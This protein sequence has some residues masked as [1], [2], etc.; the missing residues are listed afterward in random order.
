MADAN[1]YHTNL[2]I[3]KKY[4]EKERN[5]ISALFRVELDSDLATNPQFVKN[6]RTNKKEI[7]VQDHG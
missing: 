4:K 3:Q 6:H 1:F 7:V 5:T 2:L